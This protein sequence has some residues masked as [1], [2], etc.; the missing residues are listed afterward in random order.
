MNGLSRALCTGI[1]GI[2][3]G[4][5]LYGCTDKA[6]S[7]Q[8]AAPV[9]SGETIRWKMITA[10]PKNLP[11]LGAGVERFADQVRAMS[12]GRLD[13][14]IYG[15]G[16]LV[17]AFEVFDAVAAGQ[18]EMGHAASYYWRGKLPEAVF[19]TAV[20]FGLTAQE[21]NG[22]LYYGG[23]L[24]LWQE[25]YAP[26][27]LIPMPGGNT[28]TQMGGWFR[29][30]INSLEDFRGLRMRIPG[31]GGE[32]FEQVGGVA[33][34]IP[35]SEMF[36]A[37]QTGAIDAVE[38]VGA[39]NDQAFGLHTVADYYYY[40][41][42]HEG[43]PTLETLVNAEAWA[44]LPADLQ[45]I[46]EAASRVMN[47]DSLAEYTARS[48]QALASLVTEHGVEVRPFPDDVLS[49]LR[50]VSHQAVREVGTSSPM[51]QKIYASWDDYR[52]QSARWQDI[53]ERAFLNSRPAT[54]Q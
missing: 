11:G 33:V 26:F 9:T 45:A 16:E 41:G 31:L 6:Q 32:V 38:W 36:T 3:L 10:W 12:A 21:M 7:P 47:E 48:S 37:M 22:W 8:R 13:I 50:E 46:L 39:Y 17:G 54:R 25:L 19:F 14:T 5:A 51:A 15:A 2:V 28:G 27:G 52:Q 53:S 20:P 42:W 44:E 30:E 49:R 35:G 43:G 4:L 23:G 34:A 18:A 29:K 40:P 1:T 24:E